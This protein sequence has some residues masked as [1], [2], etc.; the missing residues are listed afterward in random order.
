MER[1]AF[2]SSVYCFL[3]SSFYSLLFRFRY[4]SANFSHF[5]SPSLLQFNIQSLLSGFMFWLCFGFYECLIIFSQS[6][7]WHNH[8]QISF[9][10]FPFLFCPIDV[11]TTL[12]HAFDLF[13]A[14]IMRNGKL[15][16]AENL[17]EK[18]FKES[19]IVWGQIFINATRRDNFFRKSNWT[20]D[21]MIIDT[22]YRDED[23]CIALKC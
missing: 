23:I 19:E 6:L 20:C 13:R 22:N 1:L 4:P 18:M 3:D 21:E 2:Q 14:S 16:C 7:F 8:L 5:S 10:F 15:L 12:L 11:S 9:L 17:C